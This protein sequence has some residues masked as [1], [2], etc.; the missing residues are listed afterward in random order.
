MLAVDKA[1]THLAALDPGKAHLVELRFFRRAGH[2]RG[3]R[4]TRRLAGDSRA[5]VDRG[6][7]VAAA[8]AEPVTRPGAQIPRARG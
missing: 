6:E 8:R 4:G 3:G 2:P 1:L 5:R 7:A